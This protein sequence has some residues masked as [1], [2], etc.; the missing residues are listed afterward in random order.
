MAT[1]S[2]MK[3]VFLMLRHVVPASSVHGN[4]KQIKFLRPGVYGHIIEK[5]LEV[6]FLSNNARVL[7]DFEDMLVS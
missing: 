2:G 5:M 7:Y 6:F 4:P 3:G 1:N